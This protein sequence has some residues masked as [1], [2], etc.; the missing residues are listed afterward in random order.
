MMSLHRRSALG[1]QR[2]ASGRTV[3]KATPHRSAAGARSNGKKAPPPRESS[4]HSKGCPCTTP[5]KGPHEGGSPRDRH[6][7]NKISCALAF[8]RG[9]P[10]SEGLR[11]LARRL[12]GP[13][14]LD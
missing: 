2:R 12:H 11:E 1:A 4:L 13:A 5:Q 8:P 9:A 6:R 10:P 3:S 7:K 14:R